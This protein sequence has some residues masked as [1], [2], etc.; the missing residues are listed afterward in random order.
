MRHT[1]P[2]VCFTLDGAE[3]AQRF[4]AALEL[5]AEATSFG[6]VHASA[7]RRG[8]WATDDVADG[9][10]RFSAGCEDAEDL[11]ADVDQALAKS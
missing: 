4:L 10:I 5:V 3:R 7:E 6:G 11:L 8:R 2:L 9:F 1:G